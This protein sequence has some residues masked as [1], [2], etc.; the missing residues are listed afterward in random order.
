MYNENTIPQVLLLYNPVASDKD[1][2]T[3]VGYSWGF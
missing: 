2:I 3:Q 1:I